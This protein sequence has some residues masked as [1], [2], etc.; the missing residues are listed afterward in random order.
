[1]TATDGHDTSSTKGD[2]ATMPHDRDAE[3]NLLKDPC[4]G[5]RPPPH[6]KNDRE[7]MA[8]GGK[9]RKKRGASDNGF[10]L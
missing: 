9:N 6:E 2:G 4:G 1:M 8:K 7:P 3:T 10:Q 5:N